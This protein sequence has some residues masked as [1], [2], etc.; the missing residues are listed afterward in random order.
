MRVLY[1]GGT[2]TISASCVR[3]S[4]QLGHE[5]VVLNRG[6]TAARRPLPAG[7]TTISADISD[8]AAMAGVLNGEEFDSVID[9]LSF[10]AADAAAMVR[11]LAGRTGQY[12]QISTASMYHKPVLALPI[13][14]ST[15]R[16]NPYLG[17]A[18]DKIAAERVVLD[19]FE[20][21]GFPATVVRPSHTYDDANPPLPGGWTVIERLA[22]GKEIVVPGDGTSLW[23]LTHAEDFAV[24]LVGLVGNW[25]AIGETFHITSAEALPWDVIYQIL[26]RAL[27]VE[28]RLVH[29]P[30]E[31]LPLAAPDWFWSELIVGDLSHS[32]IFD[33]SKIKRYVPSYQPV[34]TWSEGARRLMAWRFNHPDLATSEAAADAV[35]DRLVGGYRDAAKVFQSLAP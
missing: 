2:G 30:S 27:D 3:R 28:P 11:R 23:T 22:A 5:V 24:G 29:V 25:Q 16:H 20:Q 4:V 33:N 21:S 26:G 15:P 14:E 19:A 6:L 9:F 35:F 7:V 17:Y 34:V 8:D 1:I 31:F 12:V 10:T 18:R 32:V 13:V